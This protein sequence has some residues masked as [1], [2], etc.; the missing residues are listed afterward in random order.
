MAATRDFF[1]GT[2]G[3]DDIAATPAGLRRPRPGGVQPD[4]ATV[5]LVRQRLRQAS[6]AYEQ[7]SRQRSRPA[8]AGARRS[9]LD[10]GAARVNLRLHENTCGRC[11]IGAW[12]PH[13]RRTAVFSRQG[14]RQMPIRRPAMRER[15]CR[16]LLELA[17][18]LGHLVQVTWP[19]LGTTTA[20]AQRNRRNRPSFAERQA[21][22]SG[23]ARRAGPQASLFRTGHEA[24]RR[25]SDARRLR[26][27]YRLAPGAQRRSR[28]EQ[29]RRRS[30]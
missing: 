28:R 10:G 7:G 1:D 3:G 15:P 25:P 16:H 17:G 13:H 24:G 20:A 2:R 14:C 27:S 18:Q 26:C 12:C 29:V 6:G 30:G 4:V 8:P 23:R 21:L 22:R 9:D 5:R 11:N 19:H